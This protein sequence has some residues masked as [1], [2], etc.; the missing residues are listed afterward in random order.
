MESAYKVIG[1]VNNI[2][3]D[4]IGYVNGYFSHANS[5]AS[6][7]KQSAELALSELRM[8]IRSAR[9]VIRIAG[10]SGALA[11]ALG[12]YG[13]H[14]FFNKDGV[15]S[16]LKTVRDSQQIPFPAHSGPSGCSPLQETSSDWEPAGDGHGHL[17]RLVLL[18]RA[19]AGALDPQNHSLRRNPA[20]HRMALHGLVECLASPTHCLWL[21]SAVGE[22]MKSLLVLERLRPPFLFRLT[23]CSI[24]FLIFWYD[25][26]RPRY[27]GRRR[28]Q[29]GFRFWLELIPVEI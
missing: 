17:L 25:R 3:H 1:S 7:A 27:R 28:G 6:Q 21:C 5:V 14:A 10:V 11:V 15:A 16:E 20:D 18:L 29:K 8:M 19:D 23:H 2:L 4:S 22:P 12:A 13:A 9:P 26:H 24:F